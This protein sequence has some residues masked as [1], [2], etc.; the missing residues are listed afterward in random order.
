MS[1][2]RHDHSNHP[3]PATPPDHQPVPTTGELADFDF[4]GQGI[5]ADAVKAAARLAQARGEFE[6]YVFFEDAEAIAGY[7]RDGSRP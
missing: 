5:R 4:G 7:I 2:T 3:T 6:P 1:D